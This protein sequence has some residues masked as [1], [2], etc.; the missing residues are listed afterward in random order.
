MNWRGFHR[1]SA[2]ERLARIIAHA[3]LDPSEAAILTDAGAL[4]D[5]DLGARFVENHVGSYPVPLGFAVGFQI[6]GQD[7]VVPMAVEESSVIAAACNGAK[8][9]AAGGGFQTHVDEPVTVAQVELRGLGGHATVAAERTIAANADAWMARLNERMASM[10]AR[11]GGMRRIETRRVEDLLIVH[12]HV[13]CR[14]AMG[15]NLVNTLC[16]FISHDVAEALGARPGLRILTNLTLERLVTARCSLPL[17]AVGGADVAQAMVDA[18]RF[19]VID[20]FRAATHN[21]GIMNGIDPV[22]IATGNDWRAA[23][24]GAHAYAALDGQYRALTSWEVADGRLNGSLCLP[25]AVGTVGGMTRIHPVARVALKA[26]GNPSGPEL[27]RIAAAVGLVQNLAAL[28]A[29]A[30]EGIQAGHMR[31]HAR[32]DALTD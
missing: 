30:S 24:A 6:D 29:L 17:E 26:L 7:V 21:K 10:V 22:L 15:A 27:A 8:W 19:A 16:E 31:L 32:N 1:L 23:E 5:G 4:A 11:G 18:N 25:L 13:D 3:G 2:P 28:R 14:D 9:A 12:F 20:P